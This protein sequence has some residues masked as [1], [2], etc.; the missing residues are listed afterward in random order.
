MSQQSIE[1]YHYPYCNQ[2][3]KEERLLN[4]AHSIGVKVMD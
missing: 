4:Y 1:V 2:G 3:K